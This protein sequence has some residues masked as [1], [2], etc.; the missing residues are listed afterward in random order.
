MR[1]EHK[2]GATLIEPASILAEEPRDLSAPFALRATDFASQQAQIKCHTMQSLLRLI[3]LKTNDRHPNKVTHSC[4]AGLP[5]LPA[6]Q[7]SETRPSRLVGRDFSPAVSSEFKTLP[8]CRRLS[9]RRYAAANP[10]FVPGRLAG[11]AERAEGKEPAKGY[12]QSRD[13]LNVA[14][15]AATYKANARLHCGEREFFGSASVALGQLFSSGMQ[16][17]TKQAMLRWTSSCG[18]PPKFRFGMM[19]C[20]SI[21]CL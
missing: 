7:V 6:S 18:M 2:L 17:L 4:K 16:C 12:A 11:G 1:Q 8:C 20:M 19:P 5:L 15:K 21:S 10:E 3:S 13:P 14:A 9:R